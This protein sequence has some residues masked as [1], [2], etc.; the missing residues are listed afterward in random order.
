VSSIGS[1]PSPEQWVKFEEDLLDY[2]L[3]MKAVLDANRDDPQPGVIAVLAQAIADEDSAEGEGVQMSLLLTL[4]R[5]L[6]VAGN[7]TTGKFIAEA[8]RI[9]G[10][11]ESVWERIR[12]NP[13]FAV[14]VVEEALRLSSPT[15]SIMRITTKDVVLDGVA[16]AKGTQIMASLASANRDEIIYDE[17]NRFDPDRENVRQHLA[18]GS[19]AH[20]CIGAGLARMESVIAAAQTGLPKRPAPMQEPSQQSV[21]V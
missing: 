11:D 21:G 18:F 19:G 20:M 3:A 4:L 15:Q 6:V 17:S 13:D 8:I 14:V 16:I 2:Q 1:N 12:E 10:A 9:F 5:E 7:E